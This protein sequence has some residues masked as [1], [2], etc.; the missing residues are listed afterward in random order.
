MMVKQVHVKD[1]RLPQGIELEIVAKLQAHFSLAASAKALPLS[2]PSSSDIQKE[3][4]SELTFQGQVT[5]P[6][7]IPLN[8]L[9]GPL[10]STSKKL[11]AIYDTLL[12]AVCNGKF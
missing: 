11:A 6:K 8:A 9:I 7:P 4:V 2:T 1:P 12:R 5:S 3:S 10:R